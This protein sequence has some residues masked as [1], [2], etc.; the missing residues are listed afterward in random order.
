MIEKDTKPYILKHLNSINL[1]RSQYIAISIINY[2]LYKDKMF[3]I[4]HKGLIFSLI[5]PKFL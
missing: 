1:S 4:W 5:E 3:C 2:G